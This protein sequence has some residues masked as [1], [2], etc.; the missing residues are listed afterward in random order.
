[1]SIIVLGY[2]ATD[3]GRAALE[4][5]IRQAAFRSSHL[6][7]VNSHHGG[8]RHTGDREVELQEELA[9]VRARLSET[10]LEF[11]IRPLVRGMDPAEDVVAVAEET[12]AELVVIGLRRRSPVGKLVLG[13]RAQR[14]L[15]QVT[16]P[17]LA[18]K[19]G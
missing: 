2:S 1:M 10:G 13:S 8:A 9:Q 19:A 17:V 15:L 16:C 12:A 5:A 18:V 11:T 3:Q 6:V 4:E 7:V 14:I